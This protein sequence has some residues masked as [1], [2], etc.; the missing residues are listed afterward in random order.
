MESIKK[1]EEFVHDFNVDLKSELQADIPTFGEYRKGSEKYGGLVMKL[2]EWLRLE[3]EI[4][5]KDLNNISIDI[6]DFETQS[7]IKLKDIEDFIKD[8]ISKGLYEFEITIDYSNRKI[9]F[10]DLIKKHRH[11]LSERN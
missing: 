3:R 6:E 9:N 4:S 11:M 5:K 1:F 7:N 2:M 10:N 8:K